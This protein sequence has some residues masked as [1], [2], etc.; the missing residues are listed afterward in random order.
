MSKRMGVSKKLIKKRYDLWAINVDSGEAERLNKR[1]TRDTAIKV[2]ME[3]SKRSN[4]RLLV[5]MFWPAGF[6]DP[7]FT[8]KEIDRQE[9]QPT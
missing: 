6:G 5:P 8:K 3:W 1:L 9:E 7:P 2:W 4:L